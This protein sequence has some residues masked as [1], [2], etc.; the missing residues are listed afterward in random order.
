MNVPSPESIRS[1]KA[2][3][4]GLIQLAFPPGPQ[5]ISARYQLAMW[6]LGGDGAPSEVASNLYT[7]ADSL[8]PHATWADAVQALERMPEP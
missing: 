2:T 8:A 4:I 5:R 3:V 1:L 7:I 6:L